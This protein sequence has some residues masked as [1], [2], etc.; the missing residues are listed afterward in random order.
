MTNLPNLTFCDSGD[1][2]LPPKALR[3]MTILDDMERS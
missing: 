1:G 2:F 3:V